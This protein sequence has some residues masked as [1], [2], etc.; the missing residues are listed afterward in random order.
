M[1]NNTEIQIFTM[2]NIP[3]LPLPSSDDVNGKKVFPNI[4][5][6]SIG[7]G[8]EVF[9]SDDISGFW[10]GA[11]TYA[12]APFKVSLQGLVSV[13][14]G[15]ITGTLI[16][17]DSRVKIG[18]K[19]S[20]T[21]GG[22][23]IYNFAF[24]LRDAAGTLYGKIGVDNSYFKIISDDDKNIFLSAGNGKVNLDSDLIPTSDNTKLLGASDKV[25]S[26]I[27]S[28]IIVNADYYFATG[29]T[30]K[31]SYS[32]SKIQLN[33]DTQI[34]GTLYASGALECSTGRIKVGTQDFYPTTGA[35]DATKYYLRT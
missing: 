10:A 18:A 35:Y 28:K 29:N 7:V 19:M 11:K 15:T 4:K 25:W 31:I 21:L 34:T 22:I 9:R 3:I 23:V 17:T 26:Y 8:E 2:Q 5:E 20:A 27:Y 14:G 12:M 33:T 30:A 1:K 24:E 32:S 6:F 16:Q 13:T